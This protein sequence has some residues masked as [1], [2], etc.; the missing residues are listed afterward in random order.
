MSRFNLPVFKASA[1]A[2][3]DQLIAR[4]LHA[5]E[6]YSAVLGDAASTEEFKAIIGNDLPLMQDAN[7][8]RGL[9]ADLQLPIPQLIA[10]IRSIYDP[11]G[12]TCRQ[13]VFENARIPE[14]LRA[15][16]A[17]HNYIGW[18]GQLWSMKQPQNI[19]P[20]ADLSA[21]PAR[22]SFTKVRELAEAYCASTETGRT[23]APYVQQFAESCLR[24]YDDPRTDGL[25]ALDGTTPV[26]LLDFVTAGETG[27]IAHVFVHPQQRRKKVAITLLAHALDLAA[28]SRVRNV[29]LFCARHDDPA[30]QM[31]AHT[32]FVAVAPVESLV[33][34][35]D[36]S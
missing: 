12:L 15:Q 36:P 16:F 18:P 14:S 5:D 22:A 8:V 34:A 6:I 3:V 24:R 13:I 10:N 35:A 26:G 11:C 19:L 21:I 30:E 23:N 1:P 4:A 25:L 31:Y 20:R 7:H 28:R 33:L 17:Q 27:F 32:G 29:L 2:S 9:P